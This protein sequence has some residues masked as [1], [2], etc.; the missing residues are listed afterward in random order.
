MEITLPEKH[1][2]P[3]KATTAFLKLFARTYKELEYGNGEFARM[4]LE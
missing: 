2:R 3:S 1:H 4:M